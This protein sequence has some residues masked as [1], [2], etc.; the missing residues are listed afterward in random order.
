MNKDEFFQ[1]EENEQNNSIIEIEAE[2]F[3]ISEE[4]QKKLIKKQRYEDFQKVRSNNYTLYDLALQCAQNA[5]VAA[6]ETHDSSEYKNASVAIEK[7]QK[8]ADQIL[9]NHATIEEIENCAFNSQM[10]LNAPNVTNNTMNLYGTAADMIKA[11]EH[12]SI[13]N[14]TSHSIEDEPT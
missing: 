3:D 13:Q 7:A 9:N 4:E 8:I 12:K 10:Q 1:N 14:P 11:L 5:L 6:S 2:N